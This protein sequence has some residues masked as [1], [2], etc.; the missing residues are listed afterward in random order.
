MAKQKTLD[1]LFARAA[2]G[3]RLTPEQTDRLISNNW[4]YEDGRNDRRRQKLAKW[5]RGARADYGHY[6][7][8]YATGYNAG[9]FCLQHENPWA[10]K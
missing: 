9:V 2:A 10:V 5:Y 8:D 7:L 6:D 3:K 1:E 4:G